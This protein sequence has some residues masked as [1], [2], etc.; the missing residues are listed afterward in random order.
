MEDD[1]GNKR[2][3]NRTVGIAAILLLL[4]L[5]VLIIMWVNSRKPE[6]IPAPPLGMLRSFVAT[7]RLMKV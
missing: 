1:K 6:H 2:G 3:R 7:T 5:I 4:F